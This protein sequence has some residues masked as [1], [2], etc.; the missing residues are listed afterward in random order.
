[1]NLGPLAPL[2]DDWLPPDDPSIGRTPEECYGKCDWLTI[3]AGGCI[4]IVVVAIAW[5]WLP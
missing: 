3:F 4:L 1:M 5:P 2:P